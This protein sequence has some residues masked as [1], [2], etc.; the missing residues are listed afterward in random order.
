VIIVFIFPEGELILYE[1]RP[2]LQEDNK[3]TNRLIVN[4]FMVN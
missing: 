4:I 1:S 3:R 2:G